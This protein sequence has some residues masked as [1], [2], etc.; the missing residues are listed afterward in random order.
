[1]TFHPDSLPDLTGKVYIVTGGNS[2][3]YVVCTFFVL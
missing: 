3:M 2:G 1:M